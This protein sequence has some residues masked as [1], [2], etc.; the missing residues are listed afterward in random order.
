[1]TK[2]QYLHLRNSGQIDLNL[3]WEYYNEVEHPS[4]KLPQQHFFQLF[5][6]WLGMG[7]ATMEKFYKHY[8]VKFGVN[9]L[10]FKDNS[11][12]YI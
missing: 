3:A 6:M 10:T 12:K 11:F 9:K 4:P 7:V 8:D 1:M 2:E 5:Q